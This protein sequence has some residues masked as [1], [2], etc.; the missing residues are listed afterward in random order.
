MPR[1]QYTTIASG[2]KVSGNLDFTKGAPVAIGFPILATAESGDYFFQGGFDTTSGDFRRLMEM[3]SPG[4]GSLRMAVG[5]GSVVVPMPTVYAY[6]AF[7]RLE[8]AVATSDVRT[9]TVLSR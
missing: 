5:V 9:F 1:I 3:R 6:P 8:A 7:G 4:S 2:Q